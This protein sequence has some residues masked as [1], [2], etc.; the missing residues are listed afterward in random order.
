MWFTSFQF[1]QNFFFLFQAQ[2]LPR[3]F[4]DYAIASNYETDKYT[5]ANGSRRRKG[6][7]QAPM[8]IPKHSRIFCSLVKHVVNQV[9]R[10]TCAIAYVGVLCT[11]VV[12]FTVAL[13]LPYCQ[14]RQR[15]HM[16]CLIKYK[17]LFKGPII[18]ITIIMSTH[19]CHSFSFFFVSLL[20][21]IINILN[22]QWFISL[23]CEKVDHK[24]NLCQLSLSA[25]QQQRPLFYHA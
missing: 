17:C 16:D 19:L 24:C 21:C 3:S 18:I 2:K 23:R 14:L 6:A 11:C 9:V 7:T 22:F 4:D 15:A 10:S 20:P 5:V 13:K 1:V 12:I 25:L 8:L